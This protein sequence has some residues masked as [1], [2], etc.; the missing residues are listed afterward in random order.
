MLARSMVRVFGLRVKQPFVL[1]DKGRAVI[2][3][4]WNL[5]ESWFSSLNTM[6]TCSGLPQT[7]ASSSH[8]PGSSSAV[9]VRSW[10]S[11]WAWGAAQ[12]ARHSGKNRSVL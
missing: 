9:G 1:E 12:P 5:G 2:K 10:L 8:T 6:A 3:M 7:R 11:H 4:E